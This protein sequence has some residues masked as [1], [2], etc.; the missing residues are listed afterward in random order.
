MILK[1]ANNDTC[2]S[3]AQKDG[4]LEITQTEL[5][6]I[7]ESR[8]VL[9]EPPTPEQIAAQAQA[10]MDRAAAVAAKADAKLLALSQMTPAQVRAWVA[11]NVSNLA[12]AKDALATHAVCVSVLAR[13]L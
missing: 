5:D 12:D 4:W 11:A 2:F 8:R 13:R 7:R 3:I 1:N 6:A 10:A 9:P